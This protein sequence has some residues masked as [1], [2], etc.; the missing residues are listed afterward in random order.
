MPDIRPRPRREAAPELVERLEAIHD[1]YEGMVSANTGRLVYEYDP[2]TD[3]A[4]ANGSPIRNIAAI[5][6]VE[7]VSQFLDRESLGPVVERSLEHYGEYIIAR[8]G[9][10]MLEPDRLGEPSGIPHSAFMILALAA[11]DSP[12]RETTI[13]GLAEGILNQQREDGSYRVFFGGHDD[14]GVEIYPG[15]AMLALLRVYETSE[16]PRHLISVERA[17]RYYSDRFSPGEISNRLR[18]FF[19]NWQSQ[20]GVLLHGM[21]DT[22]LV[23]R[24]VHDYLFELH[25]YVVDSGFYDHLDDQ[26]DS[27]ATV[28]VA[29]ALEGINAG[30]TVAER[31]NDEARLETYGRCIRSAMHWLFDAQRHETDNP[32]EQGGFGHSPNDRTQRIDVTGHAASGFIKAARNGIAPSS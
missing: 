26:P 7:V 29:S 31:I 8:D 27:H 14:Q 10:L 9:A 16:D 25:D 2:A 19:A 17:F 4:I 21:T 30:Y 20:Y 15:E 23:R 28:E 24:A 18:I 5:H 32:R 12:A 11:S 1:W 13:N 6:D 3:E 22:D